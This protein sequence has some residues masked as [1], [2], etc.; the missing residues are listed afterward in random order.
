MHFTN[1]WLTQILSPLRDFAFR[2]LANLEARVLTLQLANPRNEIMRVNPTALV[3]SDPT[4]RFLLSF[5]LEK[6][7]L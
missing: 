2:D 3:G 6:N 1:N 4:A 7:S 5:H